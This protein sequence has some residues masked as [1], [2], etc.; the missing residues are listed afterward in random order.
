MCLHSRENLCGRVRLVAL[1]AMTPNRVWE[2]GDPAAV[3]AILRQCLE[4]PDEDVHGIEAT[5]PTPIENTIR[6]GW[7][8]LTE[9]P[10]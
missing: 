7:I 1:R 9:S 10:A 2:A 3:E 8:A 4:D 5:E 6:V